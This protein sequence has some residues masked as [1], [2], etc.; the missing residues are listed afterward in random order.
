VFHGPAFQLGL[1]RVPGECKLC[2]ANN[3]NNG[4]H[5]CINKRASAEFTICHYGREFRRDGERSRHSGHFPPCVCVG[6]HFTIWKLNG[7]LFGL[8]VRTRQLLDVCLSGQ[9]L[10]HF[11]GTFATS[12]GKCMEVRCATVAIPYFLECLPTRKAPR[13]PHTSVK[14][15]AVPGRSWGGFLSVRN[16][17]GELN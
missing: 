7:F 5:L 17:C 10:N 16:D 15:R 2:P 3:A 4:A 14:S 1:C 9:T 6:K 11:P 13:N 8:T 12:S